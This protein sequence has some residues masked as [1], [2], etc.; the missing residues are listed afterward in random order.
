MVFPITAMNLLAF[1]RQVVSV[2]FLGRLGSLEL[3][4]SLPRFVL[5]LQLI[6]L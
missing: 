4:G 2:L 5:C 6:P 3:A 1:V